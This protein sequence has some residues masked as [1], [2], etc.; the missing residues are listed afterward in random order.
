MG[1]NL[2]DRTNNNRI[3]VEDQETLKQL[4]INE[5]MNGDLKYFNKLSEKI[6]KNEEF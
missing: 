4:K 2:E 6:I 1:N 5:Y 3:E